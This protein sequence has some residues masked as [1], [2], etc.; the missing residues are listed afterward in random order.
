MLSF[1]FDILFHTGCG[2]IGATV[3]R[4]LS[5]GHIK[6]DSGDGSGESVLAEW[7]GVLVLVGLIVLITIVWPRSA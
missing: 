6:L 5:F 2:W 4:I 1:I 3:L 7:L